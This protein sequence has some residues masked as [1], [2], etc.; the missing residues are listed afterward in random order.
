M[1]PREA[2]AHRAQGLLISHMR[3]CNRR[4]L[5]VHCTALLNDSKQDLAFGSGLE[6]VRHTED[7]VACLTRRALGAAILYHI[8]EL[9]AFMLTTNRY[10]CWESYQLYTSVRIAKRRF[11]GSA[12]TAFTKAAF[13]PVYVDETV[14]K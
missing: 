7:E 9:F 6:A 5:G 2:E 12:A 14:Q 1:L 4:I 13:S 11:T 10:R 8:L 3:T